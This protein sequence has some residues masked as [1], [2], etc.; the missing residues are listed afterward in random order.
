MILKKVSWFFKRHHFLYIT[1]FKLLSKNASL[2]GIENC[3]YNQYNLI[4]DIPNSF[5]E[6]N[7][8]VFNAKKATTDF[9]LVKQL[10]IWLQNNIKGGPGLSEPS[11][12][13]LQIMLAGKGGVCS[14]MAQIFN[15]FC[16]VNDIKVREW[17]TTRAPFNKE[18]GGHSFNEI[19]SREWN[20]WI[21]IDVYNSLLFYNLE[22]KPLSVIELFQLIRTNKEVKFE[23][24]NPLKP[25]E[26]A[27]VKRNYLET[28]TIPFLICNYSNKTYDTY[29]RF[30]RPY[31]PVFIIHFILF[32]F[33]KSYH[34]RFPIDN[35]KKMFS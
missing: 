31:L 35:Y 1:R 18:F 10:S 28:N 29:L 14:D 16:V 4:K 33:R 19:Y 11:D 17:G 26:L 21:L 32:L 25:I 20:K 6:V 34:Y 13:A 24:F 9:E 2:T 30:F 22:K 3:S 23:T 15:N 27:S 5:K 12:T 7:T 8:I